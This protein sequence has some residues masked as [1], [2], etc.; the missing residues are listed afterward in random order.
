MP[1]PPPPFPQRFVKK[2]EDGKYQHFITMLKQLSINVPLIEALKQMLGYAKFMKDMVTKKGSVIFED[3]NRMQHCS[4]IATRSLVQKKEDSVAFTIPCT[5]GLLHFEKPLC[6]LGESINIMPLFIYKKLGLSDPNLTAMQLLMVDR[7]L[8]RP[9]GILQDV[10]VKVE[11]FIFLD[12]FVILD[13]ELILRSMRQSGEIQLVCAISYRVEKSSEVQIEEHLGV[14]ALA[15]VIMNFDSDCIKENESLVATLDR[16]LYM[17]QVESLMKEFKRFKRAIGW[18]IADIIG[19]PRRFLGHARFY[20]RFSKD[21]SNIA[22]PLCK[23]LEKE[24]ES[25]FDESCLKAFVELKEKLV[26]APITISPDW[27]T[28][29]EVMCDASVVVLGLAYES[30]ALY[31]EK[32]KKYHDRKIE[33]RNFLVGDLV[34]L[35]NYRLRLFLGKLK[36]KWAGPYLITQ[37]FPHG[38]IELE[39]KE[40][41]EVQGE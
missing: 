39:N 29:F 5:I 20:R 32:M 25:H 21:F 26:S 22:H 40:G 18:T 35:F 37:L 24:C 15:A 14:E 7:T 4:A 36:S 9:I 13:C 41:C 30:S 31:K 27:S 28:P 11:S 23:F 33:K 19:I 6:D 2:T 12:D 16:D 34:L 1:R 3:D 8:K 17:H 10:L 38:A